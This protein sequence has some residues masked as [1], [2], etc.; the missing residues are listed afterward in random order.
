MNGKMS[1]SKQRCRQP[2][3][4]RTFR[5]FI[6]INGRV[7]F[8]TM[9][10]YLYGYWPLFIYL[11]SCAKRNFVHVISNPYPIVT[12]HSYLIYLTIW[13]TPCGDHWIVVQLQPSQLKFP[14]PVIH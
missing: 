1:K 3:Q 8:L 6:E 5:K 14:L 10:H 11:A 7:F 4:V 9:Q 2:Q 13:S 12:E